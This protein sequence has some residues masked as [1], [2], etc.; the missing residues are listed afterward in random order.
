MRHPAHPVDHHA[1]AHPKE[2]LL[3][4]QHAVE[5]RQPGGEQQHRQRQPDRGGVGDVPLRH[6]RALEQQHHRDRHQPHDERPQPRRPDQPRQL[7]FPVQ[8]QRPGG[9]LGQH[10]LQRHGRDE[11]RDRKERHKLPILPFRHGMGQ[12]MHRRHE[13]AAHTVAN[14]SQPLWRKK[15]ARCAAAVTGGAS[16]AFSRHESLEGAKAVPVQEKDCRKRSSRP[17]PRSSSASEIHSSAVC[18]CAMSPG[19]NTTL[20][21]PPCASTDAS[22]K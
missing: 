16:T 22:Q 9:L 10:H 21:M 18:A 11:H 5:H 6:D 14:M 13:H 8:R 15:E 2:V 1:P 20:G 3:P 19:P 7:V 12:E 4:L 17:L